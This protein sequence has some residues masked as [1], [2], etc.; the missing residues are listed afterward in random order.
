MTKKINPSALFLIVVT[1]VMIVFFV[2]SLGYEELRVKL[3]PMIMSGLTIV[4]CLIA[5][6]N[7]LR[8]GAKGTMPTDDDGDVIEDE[9][10]IKTPLGAYFKAFGWMLA[11]IIGA[12]F[13]GILISFPIWMAVFLW[14]Y[15]YKWWVAVLNAALLIVIVYAVFTI[16]LQ[17]NLYP[18]LLGE[19]LLS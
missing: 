8:S 19:M 5:L 7:D 9:E 18:G 15:G 4:L 2:A 1:V 13:V 12:Y 10:K 17:I 3:M 14:K 16:G 11:L 6:V